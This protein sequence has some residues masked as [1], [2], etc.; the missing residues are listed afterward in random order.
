MGSSLSKKGS[1]QLPFLFGEHPNPGCR[2][3][4]AIELRVITNKNGSTYVTGV[5]TGHRSVAARTRA[6]RPDKRQGAWVTRPYGS[7]VEFYWDPKAV[8]ENKD[9]KTVRCPKCGNQVAFSPT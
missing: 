9:G 3:N 2:E 5:H 7:G 4:M 8:S 1:Y 6:P